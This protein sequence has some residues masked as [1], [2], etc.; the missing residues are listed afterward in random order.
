MAQKPA[1]PA[2]FKQESLFDKAP[3]SSDSF[4]TGSTSTGKIDGLSLDLHPRAIAAKRLSGNESGGSGGASPAEGERFQLSRQDASV[5]SRKSPLGRTDELLLEYDDESDELEGELFPIVP[6]QT[7]ITQEIVSI[8]ASNTARESEESEERK[9]TVAPLKRPTIS[10]FSRGSNGNAG[11]L[12]LPIDSQQYQQQHN[13]FHDQAKSVSPGYLNGGLS[14]GQCLI[15]ADQKSRSLSNLENTPPI[16]P[17]QRAC[18]SPSC[19]SYS[20]SPSGMMNHHHWKYASMRQSIRTGSAHQICPNAPQSSLAR[21]SI[22]INGH[23]P[24]ELKLDLNKT[25]MARHAN[26]NGLTKA[27]TVTANGNLQKEMNHNDTNNGPMPTVLKPFHRQH[28]HIL[29]PAAAEIINSHSGD[30][31]LQQ[32]L[33]T[34]IPGGAHAGSRKESEYRR[35]KSEGSTTNA[36]GAPVVTND[37]DVGIDDL[38]PIADRSS[39]PHRFNIIQMQDTVTNGPLAKHSHT[40]QVM[41]MHTLKTKLQKYQGFIDKAFQLIQQGADEQIFEG[42]TIVAKVMTKAWLFPKISHDL[43]YALC[44]HLRDQNYFDQLINL[45]VKPGTSD[46]VRLCCGRAIEECMS[47]N[48]RDYIVTKGYLK[49]VVATAEK[50]NKNQE[51]QRMSLSLL[52][53]LFKHSTATTYKLIE[54]GVLDHILLTC[55]RATETPITLRHAALAL[56]NLSL[57][58][59]AEAKK[60]IIQKKLPDWLFLLASQQ[61]DITRYYACLAICILG[62]QLNSSKEMELAVTKSGTMSLV[63]PFLVAHQPVSFAGH[64]YKHSQGRPKEWLIRLLPML[65]SKCREAKSMAAFHFTMEAAIKKDQQK[66]E[67]LQEIGAIQ[68][69]KEVASSPDEIAAKFA[70]EALVII[71]EEVPY[72]LSQQVPC[73]SIADVQYWVEKIGFSQFGEAFAKHMVDGDLLLQIT[74]KELEEDLGMK[75]GL[76]RKRFMRELESLKIAADYSSV[77]DSQLDQFL[78]SLSPELSVYTYTMLGMGLNRNLLPNL[79]NDMMKTVCGINNP[80]HRLKLRQALQDSK[81]IDDIEVAILSKQIDVFI[82]YRRSTGNQLASLIKVLL[83]LRGYKVFIDVDKL[84]AGK[85]DSHLLKNI[86]AAKH[87]ILVLTPHSLDRLLNDNNCED[88]IHKELHCAFEYQKNVIPIFDQQ[89]EFP[90]VESELPDDIRQITKFNGVRWVHDYQE[91]CVDK[92]ERFIKGELNRAP[93]LGP[94][95]LSIRPANQSSSRKSTYKL[96]SSN[97]SIRSAVAAG[98]TSPANAGMITTSI[99]SKNRFGTQA[100]HS[101]TQIANDTAASNFRSSSIE[102]QR[103]KLFSSSVSTVYSEK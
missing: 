52:E 70:S 102:K 15:S 14:P 82:S 46:S 16:S 40:E 84:Y 17:A 42:C 89:F 34:P 53:S 21:E 7:S 13:G 44:D 67:V 4:K 20:T 91:A 68:A 98:R 25:H 88:W 29:H 49:K 39:P 94:N 12:A 90:A 32:S 22:T 11:S 79:T 43:A 26:H 51:Q 65:R 97:S 6:A 28:N 23:Q 87:F 55:K 24:L 80:I 101:P 19:S 35:F 59:C 38:S 72:K 47:L 30:I 33:S 86:Q 66:L 54:F 93:S 75:S 18:I 61:D 45:F 50:L 74:E 41:M 103:R 63:E 96:P 48:N 81:H 76:L 78:M 1:S 56:A 3:N 36:A 37:M 83:Q 71:G 27:D 100:Q 77:D 73:W 58:S 8:T 85:F 57:Y 5:M 62:S 92:V 60:K 99:Q 69:L 31:R 10:L 95:Q 9:E 2:A 64:D